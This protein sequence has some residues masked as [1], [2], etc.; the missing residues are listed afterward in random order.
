MASQE[1]QVKPEILEW[2]NHS[3]LV[4]DGLQSDNDEKKARYQKVVSILRQGLFETVTIP[5]NGSKVC[6][7]VCL[8]Y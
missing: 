8:Y 4:E 5:N 6:L 2:N 3:K 7:F 1:S